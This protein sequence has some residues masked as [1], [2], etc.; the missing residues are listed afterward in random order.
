MEA[1]TQEQIYV[2]ERT[3]QFDLLDRLVVEAEKYNPLNIDKLFH[4]A[5]PEEVIFDNSISTEELELIILGE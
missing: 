5:M 4:E 3:G 2:L 1:L